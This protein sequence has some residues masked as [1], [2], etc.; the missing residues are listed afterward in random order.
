MGGEAALR[1]NQRHSTT[2]GVRRRAGKP[3]VMNQI[4]RRCQNLLQAAS[5]RFADRPRSAARKQT[6]R[7]LLTVPRALIA[8]NSRQRGIHT[9]TSRKTTC[10]GEVDAFV[11]DYGAGMSAAREI[12]HKRVWPSML[13]GIAGLVLLVVG[14][15]FHQ[16]FVG[17]AGALMIMAGAERKERGI[18]GAI[19][20]VLL[21]TFGV[22]FNEPFR[23]MIG[24]IMTLI[25]L[26]LWRF[27]GGVRTDESTPT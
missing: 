24:G 4:L 2:V 3:Q 13:T 1:W 27:S 16:V 10:D 15:I 21:I 14:L 12:W 8:S 23:A 9:S 20:G 25:G 7:V 6:D 18:R 19:V 17:F 5:Q 11:Q 22:I 26:V